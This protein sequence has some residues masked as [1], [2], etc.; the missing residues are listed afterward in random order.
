MLFFILNLASKEQFSLIF[1]TDQ[2]YQLHIAMSPYISL[3]SFYFMKLFVMINL[4][5][6]FPNRF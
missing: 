5:S 3:N 6:T 1:R 4:M 2:A